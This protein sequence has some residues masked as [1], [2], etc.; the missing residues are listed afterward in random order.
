LGEGVTAKGV[1]ES[2]KSSNAKT[3]QMR[4]NSGGGDAFDGIAIYNLLRAASDR[5]VRVEA[6][7]DGVAA[8]AASIILAAADHI[9]VPS[10]AAVMIHNAWCV[11]RGNSADM[12]KAASE[13]ARMDQAIAETYVAAAGRRGVTVSREDVLTAMAAETWLW[14]DDAA[15]FGLADVVPEAQQMAASYCDVSIFANAPE[16]LLARVPPLPEVPDLP[17]AVTPGFPPSP[18]ACDAQQAPNLEL[19]ESQRLA[20][21]LERDLTEA[22]AESAALRGKFETLEKDVTCERL[23]REGRATPALVAYYTAQPLEAFRAWASSAPE[24]PHLSTNYS[25]PESAAAEW[26][27]KAWGDMTFQEKADLFTSNRPLYEALKAG[28]KTE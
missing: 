19:V 26:H 25:P 12:A 11:S 2:L 1:L 9:E 21:R 18:D 8:S 23:T 16:A 20:A 22:R 3:I 7:V 5:G 13:L 17:V 15:A 24:I 28:L 6:R 14:G 27:G 4:I 10:N